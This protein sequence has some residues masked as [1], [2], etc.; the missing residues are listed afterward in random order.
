[1]IVTMSSLRAKIGRANHEPVATGASAAAGNFV[2]SMRTLIFW[3]LSSGGRGSQ[4]FRVLAIGDSALSTHSVPREFVERH[5]S[6]RAAIFAR[7]AM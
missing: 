7:N 6:L 5:H 1:M 4:N 3:L 2:G